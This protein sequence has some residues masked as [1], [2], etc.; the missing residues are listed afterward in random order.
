MYAD[1]SESEV[2][3]RTLLAAPHCT[4]TVRKKP[5]L[6][7]PTVH[8]PAREITS[9]YAG[10]GM[11]DIVSE[12]ACRDVV[13]VVRGFCFYFPGWYVAGYSVLLEGGLA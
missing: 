4:A 9:S 6:C 1:S 13:P 10:Y 7:V 8:V 11:R 12:S 5:H 3:R 2:K